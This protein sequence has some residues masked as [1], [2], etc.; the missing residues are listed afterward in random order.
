MK[1]NSDYDITIDFGN[2]QL[3]PSGVAS[4]LSYSSG[5]AVIGGVLTIK[6]ASFEGVGASSRAMY[7]AG[8]KGTVVLENVTVND[9][10]AGDDGGAMYIG[11]NTSIKNCTFSNNSSNVPSYSGG[12]IGSKGFSKNLTVENSKFENN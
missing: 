1:E 5:T 10:H 7:I 3:S 8:Y 4:I 12:A 11:G 2:T 9:F 6:N